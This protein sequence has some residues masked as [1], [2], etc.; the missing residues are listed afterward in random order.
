MSG[1]HRLVKYSAAQAVQQILAAIERKDMTV[2]IA[3]QV[4]STR[5][6]YQK[7]P[8]IYNDIESTDEQTDAAS[9]HDDNQPTSQAFVTTGRDRGRVEVAGE[10]VAEVAEELCPV[11]QAQCSNKMVRMIVL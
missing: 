1:G 11:L 6:T 9:V 2:T 4:L 8:S 10:A 5:I 3:V 7:I